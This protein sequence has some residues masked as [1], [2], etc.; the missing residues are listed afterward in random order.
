M[1]RLLSD[2]RG[3]AP[4]EFALVSGLLALLLLAVLQ[5]TLA[6]LVRNTVQDAAAQG[7]RVAAFADGSLAD[8]ADRARE[9][10]TAAVGARYAR[11]ISADY[12]T[13]DGLRVVEIRVATPL[14]LAG[15]LGPDRGLEVTG[16][17][18]LADG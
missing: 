7:A 6:L 8:G 16:H 18:A 1:R 11:H 14:P 4:A 15:L 12:T 17:A 3:A 10:I 5:F 9:L 2:Q 13:V